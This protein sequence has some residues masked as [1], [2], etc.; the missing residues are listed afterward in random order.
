MERAFRR[1]NLPN[2][3]LILKYLPIE[4]SSYD[5]RAG[6]VWYICKSMS[7][8]QIH[9][10]DEVTDV[11]IWPTM[12]EGFGMTPLEKLA[13]SVEAV[14]VVEMNAGQMV[15][16]VQL[17]VGGLVPVDF[18]GHTGGVVPL[19]GEIVSRMKEWTGRL[20]PRETHPERWRE[21]VGI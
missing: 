2:S 9:A 21:L 1:A 8:A 7:A 17:G 19:P 10:L 13:R 15:E 16:D 12:G 11:F 6:P 20:L 18:L 5:F 3:R 14:L 4:G